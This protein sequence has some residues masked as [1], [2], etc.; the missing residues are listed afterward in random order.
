MLKNLRVVKNLVRET[1]T[2]DEWKS[3]F[4]KYSKISYMSSEN[5]KK[6]KHF[7]RES[8]AW[9]FNMHQSLDKTSRSTIKVS[10]MRNL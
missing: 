3:K 10:K 8:L 2:Q 4:L 1:L 7:T 6:V 9:R 5:E